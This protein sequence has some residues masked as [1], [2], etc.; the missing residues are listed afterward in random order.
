[1]EKILYFVDRLF[2]IIHCPS[3]EITTVKRLKILCLELLAFIALAILGY[4][5]LKSFMLSIFFSGIAE[6]AI[7][8]MIRS[9][10]P[11]RPDYYKLD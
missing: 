4:V 3:F 11:S 6:I 2:D 8:Y 9:L 7:I 5:T 10:D 1:M